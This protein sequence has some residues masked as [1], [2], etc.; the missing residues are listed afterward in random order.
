MVRGRHAGHMWCAS[1]RIITK[2]VSDKRPV[3]GED[4]LFTCWNQQVNH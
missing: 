4:R 3:E 2:D 1:I